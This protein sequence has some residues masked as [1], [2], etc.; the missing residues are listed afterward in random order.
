M[1]T[2]SVLGSGCAPA[3]AF[4]GGTALVATPVPANDDGNRC[5]STLPHTQVRCIRER[6]A[7]PE[8]IGGGWVW[9]DDGRYDRNPRLGGVR[10]VRGRQRVLVELPLRRVPRAVGVDRGAGLREGAV[11]LLHVLQH[12]LGR[13]QYG[14]SRDGGEDYRNHFCAGEGHADFATCREAVAQGLMQEHA[15]REISGGDYIFTVTDAGKAHIAEH[16]PP[17]PKLT[18]GQARY[19][20]WLAADC[21]MTFGEWLRADARQP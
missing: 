1:T 17:E 4:G 19:R 7:H 11:S 15:P 8:H 16:S 5:R 14:K 12:A 3:R 2:R 9:G 21:G 20:R 13:N 18:R 6:G 10:A